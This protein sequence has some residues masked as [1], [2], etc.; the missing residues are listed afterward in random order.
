MYKLLDPKLRGDPDLCK[1]KIQVDKPQILG[2]ITRREVYKKYK[3]TTTDN[4]M[5]YNH[6]LYD[7]LKYVDPSFP[8]Y[9][10]PHPRS[11]TPC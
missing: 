5:L 1:S 8:P 2:N 4:A 3:L 7:D 9:R 10:F 6:Y 11:C